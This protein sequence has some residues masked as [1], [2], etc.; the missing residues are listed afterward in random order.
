MKYTEPIFRP[1]PEANTVLLQVTVGCTH[2]KCSFCTMYK[3][4]RFAIEEMA[5]IEKDLQEAKNTH[6]SLT[7]IF[8]VSGDAF[9][10]RA[11]K[12]KIIAD[13]IIEY[14]PDMETISMYA[15]IRN[16]KSKSS[17]ELQEL[18]DLRINDLWV[19]LESGNDETIQYMNKGYSL[20]DAY[21]QLERLKSAGI[22]Y[23]GIFMLGVAGLGRGIENAIAT[24]KL[25]NATEPAL[26]GVTTL[27]FF[28]GSKVA[29]D[30]KNKVFV[31]A[32]E[33]E[34]LEE[35]KKLIELIDVE[36]IPF[37][38]SHPINAAYVA[39]ILP[40]DREE[41]ILTINDAIEA[42]GEEFLNG[43]AVRSSL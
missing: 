1:P 25:I 40:A 4:R 15:S 38:G 32:T 18:R 28:K 17:E 31:P 10:L 35:E 39:G 14:F 33:L 43:S 37:Y 19:G 16:I 8:L 23:N 41:M 20:Q 27:G 36:N 42:A 11:E 9:A 2:N 5:Q 34:V 12:L 24:A 13:K 21:E 22:R 3:G 26:V 30:V 7:R 29:R 6:G